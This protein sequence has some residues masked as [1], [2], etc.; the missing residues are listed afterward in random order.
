MGNDHG[1]HGGTVSASVHNHA[2]THMGGKNPN[3]P[4]I[5][6]AEIQ[7]H[8]EREEEKERKKKQI[9]HP[10]S[11][12]VLCCCGHANS[13]AYNMAQKQS[14]RSSLG[15]LAGWLLFVTPRKQTTP[16]SIP[17][18]GGVLWVRKWNDS[19]FGFA[20]IVVS[21]RPYKKMADKRQTVSVRGQ[22]AHTQ[23]SGVWGL[24]NSVCGWSQPARKRPERT[25]T[26]F[27][28]TTKN[29]FQMFLFH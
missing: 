19:I 2:H 23:L 5:L 7:H 26:S 27:K 1:H 3:H 15:G 9:C 29:A 8:T 16:L 24:G 28:I 20:F 13:V 4:I 22:R 10:L 11:N 18:C 17:L 25:T 14:A 12:G 21:F 6:H